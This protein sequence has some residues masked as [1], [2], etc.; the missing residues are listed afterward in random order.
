MPNFLTQALPEAGQAVLVRLLA[1]CEA[2]WLPIGTRWRQAPAIHARRRGEVAITP[3]GGRA[4]ERESFSR[5]RAELAAAGLMSGQKLTPAGKRLARS[6]TWPFS[7]NELKL[8]IKRLLAAIERQDFHPNPLDEGTTLVPCSHITGVYYSEQSEWLAKCFLPWL[9]DGALI[10]ATDAIGAVFY[11]PANPQVDLLALTDTVID[12]QNIDFDSDL[13]EVYY[14][15]LRRARDQML[16]DSTYYPELGELPLC[17]TGLKS[18]N[19]EI[20]KLTP[21]FGLD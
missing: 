10:S 17:L 4:P 2:P 9:V 13:R 8:A 12:G 7:P 16:T 14:R 15:E 3:G 1:C 5:W 20:P 21:I 18:G 19:N 11:A 6:L